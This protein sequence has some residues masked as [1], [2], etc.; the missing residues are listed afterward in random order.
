MMRTMRCDRL[1]VTEVCTLDVHCR[2]R[3]L[4]RPI[5]IAE[6]FWTWSYLQLVRSGFNEN[7]NSS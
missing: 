2:E 6:R 3:A 5:V 1:R 4:T 7:F